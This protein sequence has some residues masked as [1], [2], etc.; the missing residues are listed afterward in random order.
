MFFVNQVI[1]GSIQ[2]GLRKGGQRRHIAMSNV[3]CCVARSNRDLN[4]IDNLQEDPMFWSRYKSLNYFHDV[5]DLDKHFYTARL[6][7]MYSCYV[8]KSNT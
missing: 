1:L 2:W 5:Y 6:H 3:Y 7:G 8:A 4:I